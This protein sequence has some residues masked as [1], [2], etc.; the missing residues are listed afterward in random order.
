[1]SI[2]SWG[3]SGAPILP[4]PLRRLWATE[5]LPRWFVEEL[6][7]SDGSTMADLH[8]LRT[9][10]GKLSD[11]GRRYL[12]FLLT[13]RREAV[14]GE[15]SVGIAWPPSLAFSAVPW[16]TRTRNCLVANRIDY[17]LSELPFLTFG[18]LLQVPAMGAQTVLDFS[19]S[20]EAAIS[21]VQRD[22]ERTLPDAQPNND[23]SVSESLLDALDESWSSQVSE[24]D[25]RFFG[26]LPRGDG[27]I[28]ERIDA[29]TGDPSSSPDE[30][31]SLA[32]AI[33]GIRSRV[34]QLELIPLETGLADFVGQTAAISGDRL[35]GLLARLHCSGRE[36]A[37][38]LEEAGSLGGVTRERMRQLQRRFDER[39]PKHPVVMPALDNALEI[40]SA[41]API[42]PR[43][44]SQLLNSKKICSEKFHPA[45][46]LAAARLCGRRPGIEIIN[47]GGKWA[48]VS[49]HSAHHAEEAVRTAN[50]VAR[51]TGIANTYEVKAALESQFRE[52]FTEPQVHELL[53]SH[54]DVEFLDDQWFWCPGHGT[55]PIGVIA[56]RILS[57]TSPMNL[58]AIREGIRRQ[59]TFRRSSGRKGR[60]LVLPPRNV[61]AAYF[62]AHSDF[63][64]L[65]D[66]LVKPVRPLDYRIE[67]GTLERVIVDTLRSVPTFVLDRVSIADGCMERGINP[68]SVGT[69][70]TYSPVI[71]HLGT[72][73]WTLRGCKPDPAVVE[74][75]R[76]ANALRPRQ[77]R[78]VDYGWTPEG[79]LWISVRLP[80]DFASQVFGVP[81]AIRRF[82]AGRDFA[83]VDADGVSCGRIRIYEPG[84]CTGCQPFLDRAGGDEGDLL[85]LRF[86]LTEER[87]VLDLANDDSLDEPE[88][89]LAGD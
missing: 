56:T 65:S 72:G 42:D 53:L 18:N 40:L 62:N 70:L 36:S 86:N 24:S 38:T 3:F 14:R 12:A 1:M 49:A 34:S 50:R 29:L 67:L 80:H 22:H 76:R 32:Q 45:S 35:T 4:A 85:L 52:T 47:L 58:T 61:L 87:V 44:A 37:I 78:V 74:S 7:L 88:I 69:M 54:S 73:L 8:E 75:I 51:S 77:Q 10:A 13:S 27:T 33:A 81:G 71:E 48:V 2:P 79:E 59:F 83:A 31:L 46:I 64:L 68:R 84:Q 11:R 23:V 20:L 9:D 39:A 6:H 19:C 21:H 28:A 17:R 30:M 41:N 25:R 89:A 63:V 60:I 57:V 43:K 82:V 5:A 26:L 66:G 55:D 16:R 15:I